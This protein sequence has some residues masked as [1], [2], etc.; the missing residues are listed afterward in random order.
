MNTHGVD[1]STAPL[2]CTHGTPHISLQWHRAALGVSHC[3]CAHTAAASFAALGSSTY[4]TK[5]NSTTTY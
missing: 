5:T 1:S 2:V 3:T 4:V